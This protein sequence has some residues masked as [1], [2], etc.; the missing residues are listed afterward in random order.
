M[1][2]VPPP[3][4]T[5][6]QHLLPKGPR[7]EELLLLVEGQP[8]LVGRD[9][10]ICILAAAVVIREGVDSHV[11]R[12]AEDAAIQLQK[13]GEIRGVLACQPIPYGQNYN[14]GFALPPRLP[15]SVNGRKSFRISFM[16]LHTISIRFRDTSA[17]MNTFP[18][19]DGYEL[20]TI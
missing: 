8:I 17:D 16:G 7:Q 9:F 20:D 18:V 6:N 14:Q 13:L 1:V 19:H 3:V 12:D 2:K 5:P 11:L 15:K 10:R 4:A